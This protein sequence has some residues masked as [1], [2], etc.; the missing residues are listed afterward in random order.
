MTNGFLDKV[1]GCLIGGAI[2]D[3]IG[4]P[5]ECWN[6][7]KIRDTYGKLDRWLPESQI[8]DDTTLRHMLCLAILRRGGRVTP[9][10]YAP[11]WLEKFN[12]N[13]LWDN[14]KIVLMKL[15]VG[16]NPWDTGHG[17]IPSGCATMSIAPIGVMN[18][19]NPRQ[20]YQ[21][22]FNI[23]SINEEGDD[24]DLAATYAAG[25][26]AAFLPGATADSVLAA[27][28]ENSTFVFQR[29]MAITMKLVEQSPNPAAFV[30]RYYAEMLD[31][32]FPRVPAKY[33]EVPEGKPPKARY[34]SCRTLDFLPAGLG[35]F[36]MCGGKVN[37]CIVECANFGR[38]CD[39]IA[40]VIGGLAGALE[41]A[42]RIR[43]DWIDTCEAQNTA[44]FLEMEGDESKNFYSVA[45]RLADC[46]AQ[47]L[48][49]ARRQTELL[50]QIIGG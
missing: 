11:L 27:M 10:D 4:A 28:A 3:S 12:P 30:E 39:T 47:E 44:L 7:W 14:E 43:Q 37:D 13:R 21:D 15:K 41:G 49:A 1:Y 34:L 6:Y 2:G 9:D 20:A 22:G 17:T 48:S 5:V 38:D 45:Q 16:M 31:Y 33:Y 23:A 42:S 8:T 36:Y 29:A 32:T 50:S 25:V 46:V 35:L 40:T 18:A 24:R 19:G 26:A